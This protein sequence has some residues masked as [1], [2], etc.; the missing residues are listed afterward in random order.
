MNDLIEDKFAFDHVS[1][2]PLVTFAL[3]AYNQEKY[4]RDAVEGALAQTYSPLEIILSDDCSSDATFE[5]MSRAAAEYEGLHRIVLNRNPQ[6]LNIGDHVNAVA[7]LANG[8]LIVLA[9]GDDISLP[10]RTA[11]L[12]QRWRERGCPPAVLC[13]D[14]DA[15]DALSRPV[16]LPNE[17]IHR[18]S[19]SKSAMACGDVRVLGATT[20]VSRSV[21]SAFSPLAH[22]VR[23]E[24]RVLPFR[25]LL[26]GGMVELVDEKLVRYRVEGGIS[27]NKVLS[28]RQYLFEHLPV[29]S[30]RTLPDALQRLSDLDAIAQNEWVLRQQCQATIAEQMVQIEIPQAR[31]LGV[32]SAFLK[33]LRQGG[34]LRPLIKLYL[35]RRLYPVFDLYFHFIHG[36]KD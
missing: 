9:A 33:G 1:D 16:D 27:R 22:S 7:Q 4:I 13:S 12:V 29:L 2:Q 11:R 34:R 36:R 26:L 35:K 17:H 30:A 18:G 10:A 32:E 31:W 14:F 20:A 19:Y 28:G 21:F 5:V 24:D 25:A 23:H 3:F 6:N 15:M 8:E